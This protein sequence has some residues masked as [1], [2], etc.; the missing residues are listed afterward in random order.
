MTGGIRPGASRASTANGGSAGELV[1]RR[2]LQ[3]WVGLG[4]P[5]EF[6]ATGG[7]LLGCLVGLRE[8]QPG[9]AV[10]HQKECRA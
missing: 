10:K 5:S 6:E 2:E 3:D 1:F 9:D 8:L 7:E 4:G